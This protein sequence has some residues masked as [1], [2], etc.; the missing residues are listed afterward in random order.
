MACPECTPGWGTPRALLLLLLLLFVWSSRRQGVARR[1]G[2]A[3]EGRG[4]LCRKGPRLRGLASSSPPRTQCPCSP[5]Q[6][7]GTKTRED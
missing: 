3:G 4:W 7:Q 5:A 6:W 2:W 1:K